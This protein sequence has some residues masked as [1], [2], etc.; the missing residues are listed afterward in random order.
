MSIFRKF[1]SGQAEPAKPQH[2]SQEQVRPKPNQILGELPQNYFTTESREIPRIVHAQ[3][4]RYG[5]I[6]QSPNGPIVPGLDHCITGKSTL[7]PDGTPDHPSKLFFHEFENPDIDPKY[8][9]KDEGGEIVKRLIELNG[10]QYVVVARRM[11][12]S[13]NGEGNPGR[14]YVE[15]HEIVIPTEEWSVAVVPQ[16][17]DI[18]EAKG[19]TTTNNS[20]PVI[21][22]KTDTLDQPLPEGWFDNYIKEV[23]SNVVSGKPIA[24]QDWNVK[25]KDFLRKL[26]HTLTC[27]P[28]NIARQISFGAGLAGSKENEVRIAHTKIARGLRKIGGQWKGT[29]PEDV[30]FGQRYLMALVQVIGNCT[31]PRQVIKAVNNIPLDMRA[32]IER[33]FKQ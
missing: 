26:F 24:L 33:R 7:L 19:V 20:M 14:L 6:L 21:E 3:Q 11:L 31:T 23:I 9:W 10:R 8:P 13:E 5:K 29:A 12:R 22:L 17:A 30:A 18:L 32:E 16:L 28:E 15:M 2:P 1:F 4:F 27:L 25:E